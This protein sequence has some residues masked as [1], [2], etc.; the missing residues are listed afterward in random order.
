MAGGKETPR[1]KM[2][3]MMY[4]VLTA[5]LALQVSNAVLEK[6]AIINVTLEELRNQ[7]NQKNALQLAA[8]QE[9]GATSSNPKVKTAVENAK[10]V[11]EATSKVLKDVDDLKDKMMKL[12]GTDAVDEKFI[13]DHSS[14][15]ATM[16]IDPRSPTGKAFEKTLNDYVKE[17]STLSGEKFDPLAKAPKDIPFFASDPDQNKKDFLTFT[18]ENTPAIAALTSATEI[19]TEILDHEA[20]ALE[21]LAREA[22]AG[23]VKFDRIVPM[24]MPKA[25]IVAAG[26]KFEADMFISASASGESPEMFMDGKPLDVVDDPSGVKMG[27]VAF[28]VSAGAYDANGLAKKSFKA[29]IKLKDS[30]Y[31]QNIEYFVAKPVI[32]VT[33]GNAPTLYMNCGNTVNIEVPALGTNYNPS[34]S[35]KGASIIKGDKPGRVTIVPKERKVAVTVINGGATLG[36]ENFDVKMIPAPKYVAK[37]NGGKEIDM[38]NGVR[39]AGLTGLRITA[40]ADENFKQEV[41]KDANYRI[42]DMEVI[43]AR[44]TQRVATLNARSEILDLAAWRSQFRPGDR[45]IIDI[46]SVTRRTFQGEDEKVPIRSEVINIPIQ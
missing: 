30:T 36:T 19:Q 27:K 46:K 4:L 26:D 28:Q 21:A 43:L 10:K 7:N 3:G 17:L 41:P 20:K 44:G 29:E 9:A 37:D 25:R 22:N 14:K 35:G 8:I 32:R 11:R 34:F 6:F 12:S 24:V 42:R 1:Q 5:L 31:T 15:I 39:G 33:T 38:K 13:N 45:L 2:I 16:M 40:E 23:T 18:F